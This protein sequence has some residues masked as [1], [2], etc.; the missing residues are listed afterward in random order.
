MDP[1]LLLAEL[2]AE[3]ESLEKCNVKIYRIINYKLRKI[4]AGVT[5]IPV[6]E[7]RKQHCKSD[8]HNQRVREV[9]T[10]DDTIV[11][12]FDHGRWK[13]VY[14]GKLVDNDDSLGEEFDDETIIQRKET[15]FI[16]EPDQWNKKTKCKIKWDILNIQRVSCYSTKFHGYWDFLNC[17]EE[18]L[19]YETRNEFIEGS[20]GAYRAAL[21][22]GWLEECCAHMIEVIKPKGTWDDK[23]KCRKEA[24]KYKSRSEFQKYSK[25]AYNVA[26]K[27]EWLDEFFPE[28]DN[29]VENNI[30]LLLNQLLGWGNIKMKEIRIRKPDGYWT[31]ENC[32]KEA[33]K[34]KTKTEFREN[35]SSAYSIVVKN[36]WLDECCSHMIPGR[37]PS[38]T[39]TKDRCKEEALKY[40]T[41][42]EFRKN[43]SS[44]YQAAYRN[45]WLDEFFQNNIKNEEDKQS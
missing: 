31:K 41:K 29:Q 1:D 37:L 33:R 24:K 11:I 26:L 4:Y 39:W 16:N 7:R 28:N 40:K 32:I 27:N 43:N 17:K 19:K 14:D 18:A 8:T 42:T 6:T 45:G 10:E 20:P 2:G 44:A 9:L 3:S 13:L 23:E 25:G 38:G 22:K 15:F 12:V 36:K 34:Y 35:N 21:K 5:D 30:Q